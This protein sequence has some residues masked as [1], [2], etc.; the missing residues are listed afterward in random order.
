VCTRRGPDPRLKQGLM[1]D[2]DEQLIGESSSSRKREL[3]QQ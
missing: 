3:P 1:M 2:Y